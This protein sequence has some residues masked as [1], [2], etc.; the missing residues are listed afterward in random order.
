MTRKRNQQKYLG[1]SP[2][3]VNNASKS[4]LKITRTF[5]NEATKCFVC[6]TVLSRGREFNDHIAS[7]HPVQGRKT[8]CRSSNGGTTPK[9]QL[10]NPFLN[11][12]E[13]IGENPKEQPGKK[14]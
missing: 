1:K 5:S 10:L 7:A 13:E 9:V 4:K 14:S 6:G 11:I 8:N 3:N 12:E 2:K